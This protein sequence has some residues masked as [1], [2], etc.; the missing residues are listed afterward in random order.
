[1]IDEQ[2]SDD[3]SA[4]FQQIAPST[5]AQRTRGADSLTDPIS[6][7][8]SDQS[9]PGIV[10]QDATIKATYQAVNEISIPGLTLVVEYSPNDGDFTDSE[11]LTLGDY[12]SGGSGGSGGNGSAA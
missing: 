6:I 4:K 9:N 10:L 12:T 1:L 11:D 5:E 8:L 3:L 2:N 7:N